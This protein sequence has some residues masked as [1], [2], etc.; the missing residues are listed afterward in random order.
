VQRGPRPSTRENPAGLTAREVEVV[1]LLA[2]GMSN[3]R[4]AE[5]FVLSRRTVDHH[6]SS[7]LRK[8]GVGTRTEAVAEARTLGIVD[9]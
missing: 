3:A 6:V 1:R 9:V 2:A 4:I 8:L 7:V 5:E